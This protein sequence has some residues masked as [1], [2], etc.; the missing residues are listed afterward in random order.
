[1]YKVVIYSLQAIVIVAIIESFFG[2]QSYSLQSLLISLVATQIICL[3]LNYLVCKIFNLPTQYESS[4]ITALILFLI[5]APAES[6]QMFYSILIAS[7][8]ATL[9]KYVLVWRKTHFFNP[10]AV[11]ILAVSILGFGSTFWWVGSV[12]LLPI[13]LIVG[14]IV[15]RKTERTILF[16]TAILASLLNVIIITFFY[17]QDFLQLLSFS[18]VS[19]PVIFFAAFMLTE[20]H[21]LAKNKMQQIFYASL[22]MLLP[23]ITMLAT[24][25]TIRPE[26]ALLIGNIFTFIFSVRTRLELKLKAIK[27]L[28]EDSFEYIFEIIDMPK[29]F[30]YVA[31]QYMEWNLDHS[32]T[33][34]RGSRRYFTI[35]SS[36]SELNEKQISFGTK[37]PAKDDSTF[38]SALRVMRPGEEM[39]ATQ[40]GGDFTL[41]TDSKA[42]LA[43]IAG[44]IGITPFIS[45]LRDLLS[46]NETRDIVLFYC[47]RFGRDLVYFDVIKEAITKMNIKVVCVVSEKE[48]FEKSDN[49]NVSYEEGFLTKEIL[50]KYMFEP[51]NTQIYVSG[52]N[53]MV[54]M[55]KKVFHEVGVPRNSL[56]T[57][58][59]PGF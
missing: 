57:D 16:S 15:I 44:G 4:I 58:Y 43:L 11:G 21:T 30:S 19:G 37:F 40:R 50:L 3:A 24:S 51:K 36:P 1:M 10:A 20:P 22:V 59:F 55:L 28:S 53:V 2:I 27:K 38:K 31:G 25:Y 33:D 45:H 8:V 52:P 42:K 56:H 54:E 26:L 47:V 35:S 41:P 39:Y 29:S 23:T 48:S 18:F 49:P 12:Y 32:R 7:V 46:K 14:L 17:K 9:S 5:L 6:M 34:D 13:V